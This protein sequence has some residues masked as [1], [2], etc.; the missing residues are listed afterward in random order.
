MRMA[1]NH[2]KSTAKSTLLLTGM[3]GI[4]ILF[5]IFGITTIPSQFANAL[6]AAGLHDM[7]RFVSSQQSD[8][9]QEQEDEARDDLALLLSD[10][11]QT[12]PSEDEAGQSWDKST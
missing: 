8:V 10:D 6:R 7:R 4:G 5:S 1:P 9:Q 12:A 2:R 3:V 11:N